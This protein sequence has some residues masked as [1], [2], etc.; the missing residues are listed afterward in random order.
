MDLWRFLIKFAPEK[1]Q[2]ERR[3][4]PKLGKKNIKY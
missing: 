2:P 4:S 1:F 3:V